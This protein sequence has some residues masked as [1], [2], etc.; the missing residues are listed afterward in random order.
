[1]RLVESLCTTNF[2]HEIS[3]SFFSDLKIHVL[4][5]HLHMKAS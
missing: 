3:F 4:F 2:E 1:M 5:M